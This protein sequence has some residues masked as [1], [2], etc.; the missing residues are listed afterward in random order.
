MGDFDQ[1]RDQVEAELDDS[2]PVVRVRGV[3]LMAGVTVSA[4]A[5]PAPARACA[6]TGAIDVAGELEEPIPLRISHADRDRVAE[7]LREAAGDGRIDADELD[8]R[9]SAAYAARTHADLVPITADLPDPRRSGARAAAPPRGPPRVR[10]QRRLG[11]CR[12]S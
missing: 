1:G 10:P 12:G 4:R 6:S 11:R 9:L 8:E 3:A 5:C 7:V 2:S